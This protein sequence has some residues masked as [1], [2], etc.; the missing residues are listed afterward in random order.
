MYEVTANSNIIPTRGHEAKCIPDVYDHDD[1]DNY[2]AAVCT[3]SAAA[4]AAAVDQIDTLFAGGICLW[5]QSG[6]HICTWHVSYD[7][8]DI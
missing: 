1:H 7:M 4:A 5:V 3:Y 2:D 8:H 6:S